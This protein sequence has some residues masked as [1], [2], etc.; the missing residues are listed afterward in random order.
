MLSF[1][2][3][4]EGITVR[5]FGTD[6]IRGVYGEEL[7]PDLAFR[8]GNAYTRFL[9]ERESIGRPVVF[10]AKDSRLSSDVLAYAVMSGI[11]SAG[12]VAVSLGLLP[13]PGLAMLV[14]HEEASGG[15]MISASHNP[16]EFNGLKLLSGSGEKL[17]PEEEEV[18][19]DLMEDIQ[20]SGWREVGHAEEYPDAY[21][22][23]VDLLLERLGD[24]DVGEQLVTV[25]T[26]HG[27]TTYAAPY[28]LKSVGA[29]A[30]PVFGTPDGWWINRECGATHPEVLKRVLDA[31]GGVGFTFDGDGDRVFMVT[32]EGVFDGDKILAILAVY[33]Q[34]LG[35]L[36]PPIVV[37]TVMANLGLENFL[38]QRG[39]KL[40]RTPV[41]D[42][43]VWEEMKKSGALIGGESSGHIIYRDV[44]NT[45]DGIGIMLTLLKL[46]FDEGLDLGEILAGYRVYPQ[47]TYNFRTDQK[48]ALA[49]SPRVSEY[50]S[51]IHEKYAGQV[52]V[53][54]RP[55]GTEPVLRITVEAVDEDLVVKLINNLVEIVTEEHSRLGG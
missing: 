12:G 35:R 40:V 43:F 41:G 32:R 26:A 45:G 23:Y 34:R 18:I 4:E 31:I 8:L 25:D 7:T 2:A 16:I 44:N 9:M 1:L 15:V 3:V 50:V 51:E 49:S 11:M 27:A 36:D 17:R 13:T 5:Y 19:E 47:K 54:V 6:G 14:N 53:I 37:S 20:L 39:I 33:L 21:R 42:K 48:H 55:S 24:F 30:N 29:R 28:A 22:R 52:R 38:A 46:M 10:V